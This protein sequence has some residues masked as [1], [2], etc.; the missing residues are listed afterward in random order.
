M[1]MVGKA[2]VPDTLANSAQTFQLE[3]DRQAALAISH[4]IARVDESILWVVIKIFAASRDKRVKRGGCLFLAYLLRFSVV[5]QISL[6]PGTEIC[7]VAKICIP[8]IRKISWSRAWKQESGWPWCYE[9]TTKYIGLLIAAGVLIT[10]SGEPGIYYLPLGAYVLLPDHARKQLEKLAERR[11]RVSQSAAFKRTAIHCSLLSEG[12]SPDDAWMV[13]S[14]KGALFMDELELQRMVQALD[15]TLQSCQGVALLPSTLVEMMRV[16]AKHAPRV[17]K[18]DGR[19]IA[20]SRDEV[21]QLLQAPG[22]PDNEQDLAGMVDSRAAGATLARPEAEQ[23]RTGDRENL[24]SGKGSKRENGRESATSAENLRVAAEVVDSPTPALSD[25]T[26]ITINKGSFSENRVSEN[27]P[28]R[29]GNLARE[30]A[31]SSENVQIADSRVQGEAVPAHPLTDTFSLPT[32]LYWRFPQG[33]QEL[34]LGRTVQSHLA[35]LLSRRYNGDEQKVGHYMKLLGQDCRMLDIAIID[36]LVRSHFPDPRHKPD[37]LKGPWVTRQYK[38]Y[39][40]GAEVPGEILAWADTPYTYD[41]ID[42]VLAE[43]ARWQEAQGRQ[44]KRPRPE[45]VIADSERLDDVYF[46]ANDAGQ[47]LKSEGHA[48]VDLEGELLTCQEYERRRFLLLQ[49]KLDTDPRVLSPEVEAEVA[50]YLDWVAP[51][52]CDAEEEAFLLANLPQILLPYLY[53]LERVLDAERYVLGVQVAPLSR[54]RVIAVRMRHDPQQAWL[55]PY[56]CDVDTFIRRYK[57]LEKA[58]E[59][60]EEADG[61]ETFP[62]GSTSFS[63]LE[64]ASTQETSETPM[65]ARADLR[66]G[67]YRVNFDATGATIEIEREGMTLYYRIEAPSSTNASDFIRGHREVVIAM[68]NDRLEDL[69]TFRVERQA[70]DERTGTVGD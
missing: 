7:N 28:A 69:A 25:I 8:N 54:R 11:P 53:K 44:R 33:I 32:L 5:D 34:E 49:C 45:D 42:A 51:Q 58:K 43:A 29:E 9:T 60:E 3:E 24:Q 52:V 13:D 21:M 57:H 62:D 27:A 61:E 59:R 26:S 55:L 16:V 23:S 12:G 47:G 31:I 15:T 22:S 46:W 14:P 1:T 2:P 4:L 63:S 41:A 64:E 18:K 36:G 19:F 70:E 40:N 56:G 50:A 67:P 17:L 65:E 48:G 39:R 68:A 66:V 6:F 37:T 20:R 30:S 10:R 35:A 38:A